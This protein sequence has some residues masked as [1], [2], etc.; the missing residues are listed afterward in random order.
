MAADSDFPRDESGPVP[1][2][3]ADP[4]A[5]AAALWVARHDRGLTA[6]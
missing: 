2:A 1:A 4:V 5:Q 3:A 6:V